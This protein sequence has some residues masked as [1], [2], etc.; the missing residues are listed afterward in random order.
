MFLYTNIFNQ[1]LS[2]VTIIH[3]RFRGRCKKRLNCVNVRLVSQMGIWTFKH[4]IT[5]IHHLS[6]YNST[7]TIYRIMFIPIALILGSSTH[8][9]RNNLPLL[10]RVYVFNKVRPLTRGIN[11]F[12]KM[13][14]KTTNSLTVLFIKKCK[15]I[16]H[17]HFIIMKLAAQS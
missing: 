5:N 8:I 10:I 4:V 14:L 1:A 11:L 12:S 13:Y 3:V 7:Y 16:K 15:I 2:A 9:F 6:M 17:L